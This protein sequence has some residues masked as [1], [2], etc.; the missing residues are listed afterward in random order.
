MIIL[1]YAKDLFS[2]VNTSCHCHPVYQ[3]RHEG[4]AYELLSGSKEQVIEQVTTPP[5]KNGG[6]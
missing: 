1:A 5:F 2:S 4:A 6:F 3:T